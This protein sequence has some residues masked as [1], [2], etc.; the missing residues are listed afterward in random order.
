[1]AYVH[2]FN[3][4]HFYYCPRNDCP[5][6]DVHRGAY[7][8]SIAAN[9]ASV[10]PAASHHDVYDHHYDYNDNPPGAND[11]PPGANDHNRADNHD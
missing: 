5:C 3:D 9:D 10:G 8:Y 4:D 1:M 2:D 7:D 11:N 6:H